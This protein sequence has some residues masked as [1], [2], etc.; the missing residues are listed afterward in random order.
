VFGG[1]ELRVFD[2][3]TRKLRKGEFGYED[4]TVGSSWT[5]IHEILKRPGP[6]NP[7]HRV[8]WIVDPVQETVYRFLG[9]VATRNWESLRYEL[10]GTED[11]KPESECESLVDQNP[12]A[13]SPE[14]LKLQNRQSSENFVKLKHFLT[15]VDL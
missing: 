5:E 4:L 3:R 10:S 13:R 6:L 15:H 2:S 9:I 11:P 1:N 12:E 14:V 8:S 7:T